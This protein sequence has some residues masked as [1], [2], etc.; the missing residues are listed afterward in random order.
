[1]AFI[2]CF[3]ALLGLITYEII[4]YFN[5]FS[6]KATLSWG[7]AFV[8]GTARQHALHRR[9]TFLFKTHYWESLYRAYVLDFGVLFLSSLLNWFLTEI[10][11]VNHRIAW[12]CC[13]LLTA[14]MGLL[15]LKPYVFKEKMSSKQ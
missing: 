13:L 10:I 2:A 14:F 3:G 11:H 6:P 12:G 7:L 15:F 4:Y 8:I 9:F 1:M 5:P